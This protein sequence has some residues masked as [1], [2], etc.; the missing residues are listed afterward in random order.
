LVLTEGHGFR[1]QKRALY[2]GSLRMALDQGYDE[3][4]KILM[5][6]GVK[7]PEWTDPGYYHLAADPFKCF[8]SGEPT[9]T[10]DHETR[11][12]DDPASLFTTTTNMQP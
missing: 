3:I 4:A 5:D 7:L 2:S 1:A 11:H 12:P 9:T 6:M 10:L 8:Y